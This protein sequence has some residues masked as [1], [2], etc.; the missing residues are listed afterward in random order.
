MCEIMVVVAVGG[1]KSRCFCDFPFV[2][3]MWF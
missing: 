2:M 1:I 3:F